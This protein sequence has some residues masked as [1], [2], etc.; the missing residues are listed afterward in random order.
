MIYENTIHNDILYFKT[1]ETEGQ[2]Q[3]PTQKQLSLSD[4]L[5]RTYTNPQDLDLDTC[6][7]SGTFPIIC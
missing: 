7:G 1:A 6:M 4:Y 5:I 3:H 2:V